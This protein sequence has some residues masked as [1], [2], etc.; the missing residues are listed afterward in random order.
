MAPFSIFLLWLCNIMT[1]AMAKIV[2]VGALR[3]GLRSGVELGR[4]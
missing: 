2:N 1:L 4:R 3:S